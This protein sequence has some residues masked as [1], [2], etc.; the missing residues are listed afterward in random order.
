[1]VKKI[2]KKNIS[3]T[4]HILFRYIFLLFLAISLFLIYSI[5]TPLTILPT[6]YL[7]DFFYN[8]DLINNTIIIDSRTIIEIIPACIAGSAYLLLLILNLSVPMESK[9]RVISI[10]LSLFI[11]YILNILR[12]VVLSSWFHEGFIYFDFTH[13]FTWYFLSTILVLAIWFFIIKMFS[14]KEIPFYSDIKRLLKLI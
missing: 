4:Y 6:Y 10:I 13:K 5:L 9:K 1:M 11:F 12:I 7:L 14:I 3:N 8:T 2:G